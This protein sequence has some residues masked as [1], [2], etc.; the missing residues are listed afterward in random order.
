MAMTVVTKAAEVAGGRVDRLA[1]MDR[2]LARM[3]T[4]LSLATRLM[5][6]SQAHISHHLHVLIH[7]FNSCLPPLVMVLLIAV[8]LMFPVMLHI[9]IAPSL[10][11]TRLVVLILTMKVG[12]VF[13]WFLLQL[14]MSPGGQP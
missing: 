11:H 12:V 13:L 10:L 7:A 9:L 8:S 1:V 6:R 5:R 4:R 14:V 3:P 2:I